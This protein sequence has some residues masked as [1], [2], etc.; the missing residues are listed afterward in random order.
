MIVKPYEE[1][2]LTQGLRTLAKR[3]LPTSSFYAKIV[4]ELQQAEAG[5]H[6]EQ[7]ILQRLEKL[8]YLHDM[9]VRHNISIQKPVPMQ[10]DI[11]II[12]PSEVMIL[13]NKNIRG[14]VQLKMKPHQMIRVLANGERSIFNHPEIQLEEYVL[15]LTEFFCRHHENVKSTVSSFS[16]STT[17]VLTRRWAISNSRFA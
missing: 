13:E 11:V 3:F 12:M 16:P 17:P 4:R 1:S 14:H 15:N 7:Y 9:K 10:L 8:A 6:G 2:L 5:D